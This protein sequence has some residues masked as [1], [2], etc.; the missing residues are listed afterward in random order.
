MASSV[1]IQELK[2]NGEV[3]DVCLSS[4][5]LFE[6]F[7]SRWHETGYMHAVWLL[8]YALQRYTEN[9]I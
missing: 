6:G 2:Y 9:K 1:C 8:R 7:M 4:C 5:M 3:F